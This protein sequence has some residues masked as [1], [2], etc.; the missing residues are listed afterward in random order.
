MT[1]WLNSVPVWTEPA[2]CCSLEETWDGKPWYRDIKRL[3][4]HREY[5]SEASKVNEKTLRKMTMDYYFD[6]MSHIK[7]HL[8]GLYLGVWMKRRLCKHYRKSTREF[9]PLMLTCIRWQDKYKDLGTSSWPWRGLYGICL[10]N[11]KCQIHGDKI[12]APL[13]LLFNMTLPCSFDI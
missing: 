4:Q 12:N 8:M 5:P 7:G 1:Q 2:N 10:K 11:H 13:T 9:V 3:I 6:E